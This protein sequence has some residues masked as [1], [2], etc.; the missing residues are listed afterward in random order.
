MEPDSSLKDAV[1]GQMRTGWRL[2]MSPPYVLL[3]AWEGDENLLVTR[4]Q[5]SGQTGIEVRQTNVA[6]DALGRSDARKSMPVTGWEAR[7]GAVNAT[8]NLPPG[9]KL[10]AAPGVDD[11]RGSWA[12]QWQLLD[13][14]LVLIITIAVW[15]LL[16]R[17]GG[18]IALLALVLS[19]HEMYAPGWLWLNLLIAM[20]LMRVAP[21]GRLRQMVSGYQMLSAAALLVALVPFVANQLRIAIYPQ[22]EPQYN[23]YQ[24]YDRAVPASTPAERPGRTR[25]GTAAQ[26][27]SEAIIAESDMLE[28]LVVSRSEASL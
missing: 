17:G 23:Q 24:L 12:S 4:G 5:G 11:A 22:L 6:V 8:L 19:F 20:A 10:L 1:T 7:F 15:R 21:A 25:E 16:G 9:N 3:A 27:R 13:F 14:F 26:L 18:V 28:E 2:D